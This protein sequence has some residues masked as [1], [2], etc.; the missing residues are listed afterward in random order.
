MR[1]HPGLAGRRTRAVGGGFALRLL[2]SVALT[3]FAAAAEA[4]QARRAG[5]TGGGKA[6][7]ASSRPGATPAPAAPAPSTADTP[8]SS[9]RVVGTASAP[10]DGSAALCRTRECPLGDLVAEA[11]LVTMAADAAILDGRTLRRS[12]DAGA[13]TMGEVESALPA[14]GAATLVEMRGREV[15][16]VLEDGLALLERDTGGFPQV[17]G[18]RVEWSMAG[19]A[20]RTRLRSLLVRT[21]EGWRPIELD[22]VYRV[23]LDAAMLDRARQSAGE[24]RGTGEARGDGAPSSSLAEVLAAYLA[25]QGSFGYAPFTDGRIT[26][27]E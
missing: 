8:D 9:G 11:L 12:I 20:G 23:A 15:A 5:A 18:L 22:A 7:A 25:R 21:G 3:A 6:A 10:I 4:G 16:Q 27:V 26:E 1:P 17:A 24:N 19:R 13:V 2:L 14:D